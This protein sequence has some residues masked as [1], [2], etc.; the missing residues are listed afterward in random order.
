MKSKQ[1]LNEPKIP[2]RN[3]NLI[4]NEFNFYLKNQIELVEKYNGKF[5]VLKNQSVIGIY[6]S[7]SEAYNETVKTEDLGTFLI[8]HCLLG[9]DSYTQTFHSQVIIYGIA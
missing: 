9:T 3:P 1:N 8:Q 7:Q 2:L 4:E 5:I 6:D